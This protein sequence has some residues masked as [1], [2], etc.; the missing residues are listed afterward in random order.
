MFLH[1]ISCYDTHVMAYHAHHSWLH[2]L[3]A[4]CPH[5]E[6]RCV[7]TCQASKAV[8]A[9]D[10]ARVFTLSAVRS[11]TAFIGRLGLAAS[12]SSLPSPDAVMMTSQSQPARVTSGWWSA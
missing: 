1:T 7:R 4:R 5:S 6:L 10:A 8:F 9:A 11:P 3:K 2:E 12:S